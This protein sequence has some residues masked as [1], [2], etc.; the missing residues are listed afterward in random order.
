MEYPQVD[1]VILNYNGKKFLESCIPSL[2]ECTYPNKQIYL[3]DNHS[4]DD[5]VS[6][7]QANFPSVKIIRNPENN[8]YC[9]AY[10]L[11]FNACNG[12]YIVCLNN[13]VTV[14][15]DWIEHLVSLAETDAQIA[16]IQPKIVS[17]F[18]ETQFEYAGASGGM[19]DVYGFPFL[20]GRIFKT[21]EKDEGQYNDIREIFWTS[22][23]AMFLRRSALDKSGVLD[24]TIVHHMDEIDLCWRLRLQGFRLLVQPASVIK[25]IGG[26]T[27]QTNSYK[28][29]YWNHRNSIYIM[30]KNYGIKNVW[31]KVPVHILLDYVA[32]AQ[33][34]LTLN[35]TTVRGILAAHLWLLLNLP[36]ILRKRKEVQQKRLLPDQTI[37]PFLYQGSIVAQYFIGGKKT[38]SALKQTTQNGN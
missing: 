14:K 2:F 29:V 7:V 23:A 13:D 6:F 17:Y 4:T 22:G 31:T 20:R 15:P 33:S 3:L 11:A 18:D 12:K 36:L 34:A 38:Y 28:K 8:G 16:A 30:I 1:I 21:I 26:A 10:N 35:F 27:I 24:E 9:A 37:M 25:H 5:D 19:M 32:V